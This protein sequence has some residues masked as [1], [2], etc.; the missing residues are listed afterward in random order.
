MCLNI[1]YAKG[2]DFWPL[3]K[4]SSMLCTAQLYLLAGKFSAAFIAEIL[5]AQTH[6]NS[7]NENGSNRCRYLNT[8]SPVGGT[9]L[10]GLGRGQWPCWVWPCWKDVALLKEVCPHWNRCVSEGGL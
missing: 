3:C 10:E 2:S 6:C 9:G 5:Q 1:R 8:W 7:L 4:V